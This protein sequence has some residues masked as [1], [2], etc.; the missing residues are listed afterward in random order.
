MA[1]CRE[2]TSLSVGP[3]ST[4]PPSPPEPRAAVATG[5]D[6][7]RG[8]TDRQAGKGKGKGKGGEED[9]PTGRQTGKG[10]GEGGGGPTDRPPGRQRKRRRRRRTTMADQ[11]TL[12]AA[13]DRAPPPANHP[14]ARARARLA[15]RAPARAVLARGVELACPGGGYS[16]VVEGADPYAPRHL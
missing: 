8:P 12:A 7:T 1:R 3:H 14:R 11:P 9:R 6:P 13:T 15:R 2:R 10:E 5:T 4:T 16:A